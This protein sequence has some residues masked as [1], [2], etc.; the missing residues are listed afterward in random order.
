[1]KLA[2]VGS[3]CVLWA[4]RS[5][6]C[7]DLELNEELD[8]CV[9]PGT[10]LPPS[11]DGV[12]PDMSDAGMDAAT[13]V[14]LDIGLD[15]SRDA[16]ADVAESDSNDAGPPCDRT[17]TL[18][19]VQQLC[20]GGAYN[21]VRLTSGEVWCWGD[22][23]DG[24]VGPETLGEVVSTPTRIVASSGSPLVASELICGDTHVCVQASDDVLCWGDSFLGQVGNGTTN[25]IN[26][27]PAFVMNRPAATLTT[28]WNIFA[29]S[30]AQFDDGSTHCWGNNRSSQ[31]GAG[32]PA[33][34]L[35]Q[36]TR[37]PEF[38]GADEITGGYDHACERTGTAVRCAGRNTDGELGNGTNDQSLVT[39]AV[40]LESDTVVAGGN[41]TCALSDSRVH[42]WG[43]IQ[44][45]NTP[46]LVAVPEG[47][48]V[49][50]VGLNHACAIGDELWCWGSNAS[51]Q[52]GD[53]TDDPRSMPVLVS[54]V[55]PSDVVDVTLGWDHT[56]ALLTDGSV[57]CWGNGER[58][59]LGNGA[60]MDSL[61]AVRVIAP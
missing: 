46:Q 51:A 60:A 48:R 9:C 16:P 32:P 18:C 50:R 53:R 29:G 38:D 8:R 19:E 54:A 30:C 36:M 45:A 31:L 6:T 61:S 4:C 3:I 20:G 55:D 24:V 35:L 12:C 28:V 10:V 11:D 5:V 27:T 59:E 56:C 44:G 49:L 23:R 33:E 58:G 57:R 37:A 43:S 47:T 22:N 2:V 40:D 1:M 14:P 15:T 17:T 13:D 42:C 41:T 26:S 39:V 52:L 34:P 7:G 21:C 25:L